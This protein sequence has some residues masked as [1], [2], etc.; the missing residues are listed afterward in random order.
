MDG[1]SALFRNHQALAAMSNTRGLGFLRDPRHPNQV[2]HLFSVAHGGDA[3]HVH[4]VA[5]EALVDLR[6]VRVPF[7]AHCVV[8]AFRRKARVSLSFSL[9][10]RRKARPSR[11]R[12]LPVFDQS[13]QLLEISVRAIGIFSW[14]PEA[15]VLFADPEEGV[16]GKPL[17]EDERHEDVLTIT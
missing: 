17:V 15:K 3:H 7:A 11:A 6:L 2:S 16:V 4:H 9:F 10:G 8:L 13:R 14:R 5:R 1:I 12:L